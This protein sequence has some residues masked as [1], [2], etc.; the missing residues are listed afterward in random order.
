MKIEKS[1]T[2][3]EIL[4]KNEKAGEILS[5]HGLHCIGCMIASSETLEQGAKV[6]G[7]SDEE[8]DKLVEEL[9]SSD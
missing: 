8:T 6:H 4:E 9:N 2:F 7:L 1:M 3:E 5:N